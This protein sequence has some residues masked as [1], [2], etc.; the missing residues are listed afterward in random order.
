MKKNR[1]KRVWKEG[2]CA[3]GM[4]A[5]LGSTAAVETM[6]EL[7]LDWILL[8]GEHG[9]T[10]YEGVLP[11]MQCMNGC[12]TTSVVRTPSSD[13]VPIKRV[14]DM[15]AEAV[16]VPQ[17]KTAEEVQRIVNQCRYAPEGNR[18]I[19]PYRASRFELDFE[20]YYQQ[21]NHEIAVVVQI[22]NRSAMANLDAILA[23]KGL[24]AVFVGPADLSAD[25][26]YF[27]N[28]EHPDVQKAI[29]TVLKKAGERG[30][31]V[32]YYCNSGEE[33]LECQQR[34]FRMISICND[35]AI[36]SS[37]LKKQRRIAT[38]EKIGKEKKLVTS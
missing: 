22:E 30:M 37:A 3:F 4:W 17:V 16:M 15:G 8:D 23:V 26:G 35:M 32:G 1:M 19:G 27:P 20:S 6:C 33:A 14:L 5:D 13:W 29:D 25:M 2:G 24:D 11:L 9:M 34:G 36:L 31:P 12:S 21:A 10:S 18:G 7:D 28:I 38:G